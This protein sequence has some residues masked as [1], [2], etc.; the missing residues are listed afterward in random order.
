MM[1]TTPI[2]IIMIAIAARRSNITF[3]VPIMPPLPKN[4]II[5]SA[6]LNKIQTI[7][8]LSSKEMTVGIIP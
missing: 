4:F 2:R 1:F 7:I 6:L 8:R 5:L 3:P